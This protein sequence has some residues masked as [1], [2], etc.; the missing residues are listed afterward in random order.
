MVIG[1]TNLYKRSILDGEFDQFDPLFF[2]YQWDYRP[3]HQLR[4]GPWL[5]G[6]CIPSRHWLVVWNMNFIFHFIHGMSSFPLT[7]IFQ[8]GYCTANQIKWPT[9]YRRIPSGVIRDCQH[10]RSVAGWRGSATHEGAD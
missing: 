8:D 4:I 6:P 5:I 2:W 3:T 10:Q 7:H 9:F 1:L